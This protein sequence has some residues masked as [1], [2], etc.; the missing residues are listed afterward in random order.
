MAEG[1]HEGSGCCLW[2]SWS[3]ETELRGLLIREEK[4]SPGSARVGLAP[5]PTDALYCYLGTIREM[6]G[7]EIRSSAGLWDWLLRCAGRAG[8]DSISLVWGLKDQAVL[9][10]LVSAFLG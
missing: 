9:Q 10:A 4:C 3:G 8:A 1:E 2:F 5:N 7:S 6:L